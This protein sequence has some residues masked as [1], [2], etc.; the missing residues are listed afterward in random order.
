MLFFKNHNIRGAIFDIDGTLID[1][2]SQYLICFNIGLEG[3]GVQP[4]FK[5]V[6]FKYL[7]MGISLKDILRNILPD[8]KNDDQA[9]DKVAA[10]MTRQLE[11]HKGK[12][13]KKSRG[14]SLA[15]GNYSG[16]AES[17]E[18][19]R[20]VAKTKHFVLESMSVDEAIAQME[21]LEHNFF[22][23]LDADVEEIKLLYRRNDG[24]YGL[25]EPEIG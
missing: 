24:N 25:I 6:L 21:H 11:R 8:D 7:G 10:I 13:Y 9:V 17:A 12:L 16:A 14:N 1:S 23:F 3:I 20:K 15:R 19:A 2:L 5:D 4:I 18:T 22:L